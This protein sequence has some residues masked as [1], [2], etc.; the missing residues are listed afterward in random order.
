MSFLEEIKKLIHTI[1]TINLP[2]FLFTVDIMDIIGPL[3]RMIEMALTKALVAIIKS[4]FS[5]ICKICG[6]NLSPK[7]DENFGDEN[8][9]NLIKDNNLHPRN[10]AKDIL[11]DFNNRFGNNSADLLTISQENFM[12]FLNF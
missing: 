6:F 9:N 12:N 4:I 8:F 5:K 2:Q 3:V 7:P 1:P 11:N 10:I